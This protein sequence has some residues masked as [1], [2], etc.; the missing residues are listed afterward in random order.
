[1]PD[2]TLPPPS[3][4]EAQAALTRRRIVDAAERLFL[5]DGYV[6]S[7][8]AA[9]ATGAGVS[10]QTIYN[11][12]GNKAA[13]LSAVLDLAASGPA[14]PTP[15]PEFMAERVGRAGT[16]A[17]VVAVLA[18]WFVEV[19]ARTSGVWVVIRQAAAVDVEVAA[20]QRRRDEQRLTNYRRAAAELRKRGALG[21]LSDAQAAAVIWTTGHPEAYRTLTDLGWTPEDYHDLVHTTLTGALRAG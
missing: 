9:V 4:R 5:S 18:E 3:L 7:S 2:S 19:N 17:E 21:E 10:I 1:M 14:A 15:V 8:I 11:S 16:A 13:L 12:V 6:G 20:V